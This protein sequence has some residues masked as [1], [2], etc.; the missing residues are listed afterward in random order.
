MKTD[1]GTVKTDLA[2]NKD[3]IDET[4]SDLRSAHR[5]D[6]GVMSGLLA[7]NSKQIQELRDLGDQ[8]YL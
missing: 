6:M 1:V 7:T 3:A 8:E 2:S 5:G 4:R